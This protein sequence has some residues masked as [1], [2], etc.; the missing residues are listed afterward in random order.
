[1]PLT[2][3]IQ[4]MSSIFFGG[5]IKLFFRAAFGVAFRFGFFVSL[6]ITFTLIIFFLLHVQIWDFH[7]KLSKNGHFWVPI[8]PK[9]IYYKEL[10]IIWNPHDQFRNRHPT[11][12]KRIS[13]S[14]LNFQKLVRRFTKNAKNFITIFFL[15]S[16]KIRSTC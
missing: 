14:L 5:A 16:T 13:N 1:M 2:I 9:I 8:L 15:N 11:C 6:W 10:C 12:K 3:I 4:C 7:V